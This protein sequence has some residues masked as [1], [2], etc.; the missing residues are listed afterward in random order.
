MGKKKRDA[1]NAHRTSAAAGS[2]AALQALNAAQVA[3]EL[4]EYEHSDVME[5]G[6]ALDTVA[7]LGL[8][9]DTVFKTL[10][11]EA[12]GRPAVG[13]VPASHQLNLKSLAKAL[14]AKHAAMMDP[15]KAER[16]TGYIRGGISPIGQ[17]TLYPTVI[18]AA[19]Q[20]LST[21]IISGGKRSLSVALAPADLATLV[22]A[23]FA[24]IAAL[25]R[26]R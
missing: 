22:H 2:T 19:A 11:V 17:R 24:P 26:G 9:P 18:D 4:I 13:I 7:V 23:S 8:D 21:M 15:A 25:E 3:Y 6:F 12:D 5:H 20:L 16:L 14:G 10:M 1:K